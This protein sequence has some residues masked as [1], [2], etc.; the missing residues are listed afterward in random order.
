MGKCFRK[1]DEPGNN[2][3][4]MTGKVPG[5]VSKLREMFSPIK[6]HRK[7]LGMVHNLSSLGKIRKNKPGI[8]HHAKGGAVAHLKKV[9]KTSTTQVRP[10]LTKSNH[11]TA[12]E[13]LES[14]VKTNGKVRM[15][16]STGLGTNW[17]EPRELGQNEHEK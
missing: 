9:F 2:K 1:Q 16:A 3:V 12:Q 7:Q 13:Q 17:D 15:S 14:F 10:N 11:L 5:N 6:R 8:S 4:E